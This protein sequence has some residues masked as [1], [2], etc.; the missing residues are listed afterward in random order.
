[1]D[2]GHRRQAAD[3]GVGSIRGTFLDGSGDLGDRL[4]LSYASMS[5]AA[6]AL[7][8]GGMASEALEPEPAVPFREDAYRSAPRLHTRGT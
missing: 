7:I 8:E 2:D 6:R 5:R 1:M 4:N 3:C